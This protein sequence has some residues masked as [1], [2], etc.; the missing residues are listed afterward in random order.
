MTDV[1]FNPFEHF[2]ERKREEGV[3]WPVAWWG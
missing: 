1:S 3:I 2:I